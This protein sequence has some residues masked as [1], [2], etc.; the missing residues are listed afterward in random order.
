MDNTISSIVKHDICTGCGTCVALCPLNAIGLIVDRLLRENFP[1]IIDI[2]FTAHMEEELDEIASG[3]REWVPVVDGFYKPFEATL[4]EAV[5]RI[6]KVDVVPESAGEICQICGRPMVIKTGRFGRFIACSGYPECR[7][8][9]PL[10]AKLG[11]ACP[12]CGGEMV[13]RRSRKGRTFYGCSNYPNCK[14]GTPNRP[15][16]EPCPQCGGLMVMRGK[17]TARCTK[18]QYQSRLEEAEAVGVR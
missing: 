18:C 8:T 14:F 2:G 10:L 12:E 7:N 4:K 17:K 11:V 3:T 5:P 15:I 1:D 16:P 6:E 9:K 13:I